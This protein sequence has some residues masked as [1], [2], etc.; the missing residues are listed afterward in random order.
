MKRSVKKTR[1]SPKKRRSPV[2][3]KYQMN[4]A[5]Q[6]FIVS[7]IFLGQRRL[8]RS[9][10]GT[11]QEALELVWNVSN[12]LVRELR[13]DPDPRLR[14]FFDEQQLNFHYNNNFHPQTRADLD[15][16]LNQIWG[17]NFGYIIHRM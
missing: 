13:N 10:I 12:D 14:H 2:K 11:H 15:R 1:R 9:L 16:V 8:P 3:R 6:S 17:P 7:T 4:G 5:Q